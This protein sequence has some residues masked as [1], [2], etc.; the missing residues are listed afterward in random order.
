MSGHPS[1]CSA[2]E[3][4]R[5][6]GSAP[7][8]QSSTASVSASHATELEAA[9][10]LH[11]Q[12]DTRDPRRS[13]LSLTPAGQQ[14]VAV[15]RRRLA[16]VFEQQLANWPPRQAAAFVDGLERFVTEQ[17]PSDSSP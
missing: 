7:L 16:A 11:R 12:A 17:G 4:A 3:K 14:A 2:V 5:R 6:G 15:M 9:G 8:T 10:L 13:L 1:L